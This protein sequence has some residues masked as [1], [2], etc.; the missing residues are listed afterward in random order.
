MGFI[1][2]RQKFFNIHKWINV[3]HH[4]NKL[5]YK[6]H[7]IISIDAE[8]DWQYLMPIYDKHC[9]ESRH[10]RIIT[11]NNK[12]HTQQTHTKL[13]QWRNTET[14]AR[15]WGCPLSPLLFNTVLEVLAITIIEK[16]YWNERTPD[17][18]RS[19][20]LTVWRWHDTMHRKPQK[21]T[22]KLF[23]LINEYSKVIRY[24]INTQK[25]RASYTLAMKSQKD[26]LGT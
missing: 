12:G 15:R 23:E 1:P 25:S 24:K 4:I 11:K 20:T 10:R 3:I 17:W 21:A 18:K 14:S 19:T 9:P 13:S 7:I 6:D 22:R 8:K 16:N 2:G 26:K 5:K